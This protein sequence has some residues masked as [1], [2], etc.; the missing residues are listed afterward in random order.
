[1]S[2][3]LW[4]VYE[5]QRDIILCTNDTCRNNSYNLYCVAKSFR[6]GGGRVSIQEEYET[7][8]VAHTPINCT[9]C[10][11]TEKVFT[12]TSTRTWGKR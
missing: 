3:R 5:N 10:T 6:Y 4:G 9:V 2:K 11:V 12:R 7:L 1:M 8:T